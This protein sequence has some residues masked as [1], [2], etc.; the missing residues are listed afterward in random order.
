MEIDII[1]YTAAQFSVLTDEQ[2]L[3]VKEAQIKKNELMRDLEERL[4]NEK[5]KLVEKGMLHSGIWA[6]LEQKLREECETEVAWIRET[7]L[8]YLRYSVAEEITQAPYKVDFSL[9]DSE[10]LD[11]VKTYYTQAYSDPLERLNVYGKDEVAM[12][13]LGEYYAW[14]YDYFEDA[15]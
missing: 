5:E 7:L 2:L 8:F 3:Q 10:R 14:L 4:Q 9:S 13:Y 15:L 1:S 12:K 6:K 11:I